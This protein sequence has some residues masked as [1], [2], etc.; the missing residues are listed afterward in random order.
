MVQTHAPDTGSPGLR[1][2]GQGTR[3]HTLQLEFVPQLKLSH[4]ATK[5]QC[6]QINKNKYFL[7]V[8]LFFRKHSQTRG[9]SL[10]CLNFITLK[11]H[12]SKVSLTQR[13]LSCLGGS[14]GMLTGRYFSLPAHHFQLP[15]KPGHPSHP[16][17]STDP[18]LRA[19]KR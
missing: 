7:K 3:S 1:V 19:L 9:I 11:S 15:S 17:Q 6:H 14:S 10:A 4:A 8:W 5:A 2:S 16:R 12:G 18:T 13:G